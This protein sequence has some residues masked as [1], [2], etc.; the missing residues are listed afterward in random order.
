MEGGVIMIDTNALKGIIVSSGR[1]QKQVYETM[2][3]SKRQWE[4]RMQNKKMDSNE[5]QE[6]IKILNIDNPMPIFFANI[7]T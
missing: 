6:L 3:M 4:N 7:D 5:I 2:G 1:T